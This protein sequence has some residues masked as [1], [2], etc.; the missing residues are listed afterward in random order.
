MMG[1]LGTISATKSE[2]YTFIELIKVCKLIWIEDNKHVWYRPRA[3]GPVDTRPTL[4]FFGFAFIWFKIIS[5]PGKSFVC[6]LR[7]PVSKRHM[8]QT[9]IYIGA[10]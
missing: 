8:L 3:G 7:L 2:V 4:F 9:N 6:L 1:I 5:A 10:F